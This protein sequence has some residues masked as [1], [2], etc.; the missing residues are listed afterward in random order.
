[1]T[2]E[3]AKELKDAGFPQEI[4]RGGLVAPPS[5]ING[6]IVDPVEAGMS[7]GVAYEPTLEELI[8][9]CPKK[10]PG[11]YSFHL[12]W[13]SVLDVG[14]KWIAYYD[15]GGASNGYEGYGDTPT[16]AVARLWLAVYGNGV[17]A[18]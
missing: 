17:S 2:H 15:S 9:A 18:T 10:S 11:G 3:L 6:E 1:M 13:M 7:G 8:N 12:V 5:A 16:D 4:R 14:D